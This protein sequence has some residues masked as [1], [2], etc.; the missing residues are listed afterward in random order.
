MSCP[1]VLFKSDNYGETVN[2]KQSIYNKI[3]D[4]TFALQS[5][6]RIASL[7]R[8]SGKERAGLFRMLDELYREGAL[9]RDSSFRYGTR[10]QFHAVEGTFSANERGFGFVVPN[11]KTLSDLFI[12]LRARGD[13]LHGDRVLAYKV[14]GRAGDEGEILCVLSRG[15]KEI[16]GV[17][18]ENR[19]FGYLTP[20]DKKFAE[21]VFIPAGKSKNCKDGLKAV[22]RITDYGDRDL[23]GEIIE[24]LG[25]DGDFLVEEE[26]I[27]R[28]YSLREEFPETVLKE[29]EH[30]V[31]RPVD[32]FQGR[33]DLR[34]E[35]IIT[36]DGED[37]RDIDDA[38]SVRKADGKYYLGVHIADVS[39]YV[40]P[41]SALDKE[42]YARG[43]SV[44][45][46]DR[47]LPMLPKALSN[48]ICSLNENED[49]YA[50][51]CLMTISENGKV[52]S[53]KLTPSVICS[54]HR[55][56][57]TEVTAIYEGD[58]KT[59]EKYPDLTEF[60]QDAV[61]LTKILKRAREN[62]GGVELDVKEVKII[63]ENGSVLIPDYQRSISHEMIEQ[64][65]VLANE[66]VATLMRDAEMPLIYRVHEKPSPEKAT[67]F[68]EFLSDLGIRVNFQTDCVTPQD[69]KKVLSLAKNLPVYPIVNR[70]MLRSMMKAA[71][72]PDNIGHFGLASDCY[73]HFTSPIRRYPDLVVHR[74]VKE[75]LSRGKAAGERFEKLTKDASVQSSLTE[76]NAES[77]E[78]EVDN[79]YIVKY[80]SDKI[81]ESYEATVSG[82]TSFGIFAE[83][84]N[85]VEGLIPLDTLPDDSYAFIEEKLLL[86][87]TRYSFR[88][89]Q[90][91]RVKVAAV[92][93][94]SRRV[95]FVLDEV[96]P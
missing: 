69:Y 26:A 47:V 65:M 87:G 62:K 58:R 24:I 74:I 85:T 59:R 9:L 90:E 57:Y 88:I 22:A 95:L 13:A 79:L 44:Y 25:K 42:A 72:S 82:V 37:T 80:M 27:I 32:E 14:G 52:L 91:L 63:Y 94:G 11:D 70:V 96:T 34:E 15:K 45:F 60:V 17:Y 38:I 71:Y 55:M 21:N 7:L 3:A 75:Y 31:L 36:V 20:D 39:H 89:G 41:N 93:W 61:R 92:D 10:E 54:R 16:V 4:G 19:R 6:E 35:L 64:F 30:A 49:R 56:T 43:T 68:N 1:C 73:C 33:L 53:K 18:H 12:P 29:A 23:A 77:C 84:K 28:S 83:L 40:L 2:A 86:R 8:L 48:G 76:R 66:S 46:P 81:G 78:R 50:L 51:S 67:A 5:G